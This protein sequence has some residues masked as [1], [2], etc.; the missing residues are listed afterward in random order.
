MIRGRKWR[1][2]KLAGI[3]QFY[4][5]AD[6]SLKDAKCLKFQGT[7]SSPFA[8]Q[9]LQALTLRLAFPPQ[10]LSKPIASVRENVREHRNG[11]AVNNIKALIEELSNFNYFP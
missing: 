1:S 2:N 7:V 8:E 11:I 6:V 4:F 9:D 3:L 10:W 5:R